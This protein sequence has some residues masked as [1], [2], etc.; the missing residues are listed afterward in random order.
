M[1]F[2]FKKLDLG[3]QL[4]C[5]YGNH[6]SGWAFAVSALCGSHDSDGIYLDTFI[7]RTYVW[8]QKK[9]IKHKA[10]IPDK[11]W[12]GI[13]HVPP[14]VPYWFNQG[15]TNKEIF[16]LPSWNKSYQFCRGLFTL[17]KYHKLYLE[18]I[19]DVPIDLLLHPMEIPEKKWSF[20]SFM[21]NPSK[22]IIQV[23]WW[24]R[25]LHAIFEFPKTN[26]NKTFLKP[27]NDTWFDSLMKKERL[28]RIRLGKFKKDMYESADILSF[29]PN[30]E[31]DRLLSENIVFVYLYDAS[32]N[33][34]VIECIARNT[35]ILTNKIPP[36][37]E[38][39]GEDYPFYFSS[40]EE[41]AEK[42]NDFE[43]VYSTYEYLK[44]LPIKSQL[45]PAYFRDS[46]LNSNLFRSDNS[47]NVSCHNNLSEESITDQHSTPKTIYI[48]TP[49]LNSVDTIDQTIFSVVS[50]AGSFS[51]KYHV[52]DGGSTDGTLE[53][54]QKWEERLKNDDFPIQCDKL[55]FTYE[56]ITDQGMYDAIVKGFSSFAISG[57]SFMAW[58]NADDMLMAGA[59]SLVQHVACQFGPEHI[60][61]LTGAS[62]ILKDDKPITQ[63]DRNYSSE[64]IK[65]GCCDGKHWYFVQQEGTFFRKWLWDKVGAEKILQQF[66]YAGDWNLWQL[67]ANHAQLVTVQWP[68]GAFRIHEGQ[69]TQTHQHLYEQEIENTISSRQ[70]S[71]MFKELVDKKNITQRVLKS[72]YPD[73]NFKLIEKGAKSQAYYYYFQ[74]FGVWPKNQI[75]KIADEKEKVIYE[76]FDS[77]SKLEI[78]DRQK[79]NS[80]V[81]ENKKAG[82]FFNRNIS[83]KFCIVTTCLDAAKNIDE[84]ILSII[85]QAGDFLIH[86]HVQDRGSKDFT[87]ERLQYWEAI[88]ADTNPYLNCQGITFTWSSNPN[89]RMYDAVI[90]GF[91]RI[92]NSSSDDFLFWI[93]GNDMLLPDTLSIIAHIAVN[94]PEIDWIGSSAQYI[95]DNKFKNNQLIPMPTAIIREGLFNDQDSHWSSLQNRGMFFKKSL[96]FRSKH[97]LRG[98]KIA[99]SWALWREFARHAEYYQCDKRLCELYPPK[100]EFSI[101]KRDEYISEINAAL[102]M[103]KRNE[104]LAY[105]SVQRDTLYANIIRIADNTVKIEREYKAT[106]KQFEFFGEKYSESETDKPEMKDI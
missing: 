42:V 11:E 84:T 48:V 61:W 54:L 57:D 26:Y 21:A 56:S 70:R 86:Y 105:L 102:P 74:N 47:Y 99:G 89:Q 66:K 9:S 14:V 73:G 72:S 53:K 55:D 3:N 32:A 45:T 19:L 76:P 24:L 30:S 15:N 63:Q 8:G 100:N 101:S 37:V 27:R 80:H 20:D 39:L 68:L 59:L 13:I 92:I 25:N 77:L 64:I 69:L 81:H 22:R 90:E 17:S 103:I 75:N 18:K 35:P 87:L 34:A 71:K 91:D 10:Y 28:E 83:K 95:S 40:Y 33:N 62:L 106:Q 5:T 96:W 31:Y 43:V 79:K 58:L 41:A 78:S 50:Q 4:N 23:G 49:C 46:I 104:A 52:Q 88:L 6:R 7:E 93:D 12:V 65:H 51:I 94:Y 16:S 38:Y 44:R 1:T 2:Q 85:S 97:A 29:V 67:F 60:S 82:N 98:F 36:V